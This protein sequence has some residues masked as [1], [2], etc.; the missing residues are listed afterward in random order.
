LEPTTDVTSVAVICDET[1]AFSGA[2]AGAH[3][4]AVLVG[5]LPR[6]VL[7]GGGRA[8]R[9]ERWVILGQRQPT[10]RVRYGHD[11]ELGGRRAQRGRRRSRSDHR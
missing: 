9:V 5:P 4:R 8:G 1:G 7:C 6:H 2:A 3:V 10:D 11:F